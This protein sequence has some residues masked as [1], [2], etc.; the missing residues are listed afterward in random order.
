M[1][2]LLSKY[3]QMA[4]KLSELTRQSCAA[5][6]NEQTNI[7]FAREDNVEP[8]KV[9]ENCRAIAMRLAAS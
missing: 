5:K 8:L 2:S 9:T 4:D 3:S 6:N 1:Q 7:C